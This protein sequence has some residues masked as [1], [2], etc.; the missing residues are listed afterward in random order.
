MFNLLDALSGA[1]SLGTG[2]TNSQPVPSSS[3]SQNSKQVPNS[4]FRNESDVVKV[5]ECEIGSSVLLRSLDGETF[6]V[7]VLSADVNDKKVLIKQKVL[8]VL[9]AHQL[10]EIIR[11]PHRVG[12]GSVQNVYELQA[13]H[14][15]RYRANPS[16]NTESNNSFLSVFSALS[17]TPSSSAP[18][19]SS[20]SGLL[21]LELKSG[22]ILKYYLNNPLP[23]VESIKMKMKILGLEGHYKHKE[24]PE[25]QP[26]SS[27]PLKTSP[28]NN[29]NTNNSR[30]ANNSNEKKEKNPI[31]PLTN[32]SE[33]DLIAIANY[34]LEESKQI[35]K[36]FN[37]HPSHDLIEEMMNLFR[38]TVEHFA[39]VPNNYNYEKIIYCIQRF[40][41]RD[42]VVQILEENKKLKKDMNALKVQKPFLNDDY[43][44]VHSPNRKKALEN[45]TTNST[46]Q[47]EKQQKIKKQES[48]E[49]KQERKERKRGSKV[50][51]EK[52]KKHGKC[53]GCGQ[54]HAHWQEKSQ[55]PHRE[56]PDFNKENLDWEHS[57]IGRKIWKELHRRCIPTTAA[58]EGEEYR[59]SFESTNSQ[60]SYSEE[61]QTTTVR[62]PT[63][64]SADISA[65]VGTKETP[66]SPIAKVSLTPLSL[67][68]SNNN[69]NNNL[70][71]NDSS[72][73]FLS[74][75]PTSSFV[76]QPSLAKQISQEI[77]HSPTKSLLFE[78]NE[79]EQ[80]FLTP[81]NQN[82][83]QVQ[84]ED[85]ENEI[86]ILEVE[87]EE[88]GGGPAETEELGNKENQKTILKK[89]S[90]KF[91]FKLFGGDDGGAD[92][93]VEL[94]ELLEKIDH[95]FYEMIS[96]FTP[97]A[98]PKQLVE[99]GQS[100]LVGK[101]S[102][103]EEI[104]RLLSNM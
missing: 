36:E 67:D 24:Q 70:E 9:L 68:K 92:V 83:F 86:E 33:E 43:E 100:L 6:E 35:E 81:K 97:A 84:D 5:S 10:A 96:S 26:S 89:K 28:T 80:F 27:L 25:S 65:I 8:L 78:S 54:H 40:L 46:V 50:I 99:D 1:I 72:N 11:L 52:V 41:I 76:P 19:S 79:L 47:N 53:Q 30:S 66:F 56:H 59:S 32:A 77:F 87:E 13:L 103:D 64:A 31:N 3:S 12:Y 45:T 102:L 58:P 4:P 23:C 14:K 37:L 62:T 95:E 34:Y 74:P 48:T 20:A 93:S 71:M 91:N 39:N 29:N 38:L 17:S 55:C 82:V 49:S 104:E 22:K 73:P 94:S 18:S 63:A 7:F 51:K 44:I 88:E 69:N 42:D 98:A 61:E 21:V 85:D 90:S 2:S 57:M 60:E 75:I 15:L 101:F 16:S